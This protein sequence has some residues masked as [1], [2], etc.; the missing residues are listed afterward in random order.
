MKNK[1]ALIVL[2]PALIAFNAISAQTD[3][4]VKAKAAFGE[5][6]TLLKKD[7]GKTW[8][9]NLYGALMFVD[10]ATKYFVANEQNAAGT[11]TKDGNYFT[12]RLDEKAMIANTA[13]KID[14]KNWTMVMLPLP[15]DNDA[16]REL[17]VHELFHNIQDKL[18]LKPDAGTNSHLDGK[19]ARIY[20]QL[21]WNALLQANTTNDQTKRINHIKNALIFRELRRLEYTGS[22]VKE[23]CLELQEG[24]A[25]YTGVKLGIEKESNKTEFITKRVENAAKNY[26]SFIRAFAY[27]SGPLYGLL[28]DKSGKNWRKGL[29]PESDLGK[30]LAE[31]Y[32][33]KP[34][35][36]PQSIFDKIKEEYGSGT[37]Q[38]F[39]NLREEKN[40]K[41]V[42]MYKDKFINNPVLILPNKKMQFQFNPNELVALGN[43]GNVYPH[44]RVV[45]NWGILTAEEG[46][47]IASDWMS[48]LVSAPFKTKGNILTG[49]GWKVE[50]NEKWKA[51]PKGNSF[52]LE[53]IK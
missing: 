36:N 8:G 24:L 30:L 6:K 33:I 7:N 38:K 20:M 51:V 22:A 35:S 48:V 31:K 11:F 4:M 32:S 15:E 28:L 53:E 46:A 3:N 52:T 50:L 25:E 45:A 13:L 42:N 19:T 17:I 12:G 9:I 23:N 14:E 27:V 44:L 10:P 26:P 47:V 41:T 43:T 34:D 39:E 40:I 1:T 16:K 21:E 37:I 18:N 5:I 49:T 29:A 2:I